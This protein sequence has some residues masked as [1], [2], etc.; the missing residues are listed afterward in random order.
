MNVWNIGRLEKRRK[1]KETNVVRVSV[2]IAFKKKNT[3]GDGRLE[4]KISSLKRSRDAN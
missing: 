3:I 1:E 4:L 2:G